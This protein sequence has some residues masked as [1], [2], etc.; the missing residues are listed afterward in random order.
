MVKKS[1]TRN[2]GLKIMAKKGLY[3]NIRAKKNRI[4]NGSGEKMKKGVKNGGKKK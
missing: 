1:S 4:A 2:V 3:A